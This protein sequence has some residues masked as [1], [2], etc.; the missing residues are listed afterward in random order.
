MN[1]ARALEA[2]QGRLIARPQVASISINEPTT[3]PVGAGVE[4]GSRLPIATN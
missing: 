2:K 1:A 4:G 3:V